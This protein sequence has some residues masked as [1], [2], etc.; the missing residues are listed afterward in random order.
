MARITASFAFMAWNTKNSWT[1]ASHEWSTL[2]AF[3]TDRR[4]MARRCYVDKKE[5]RS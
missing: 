5:L 4:L 1:G 3:V 2:W